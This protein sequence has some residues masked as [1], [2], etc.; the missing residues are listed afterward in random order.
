MIT[1]N[2]KIFTSP[3]EVTLDLISG[4][5]KILILFHLYNGNRKRYSEIKN[6]L[7]GVSEKMLSQ[8]LRE[9]ERD[10]LI[11]KKILS[12]KPY[13]VEYFLTAKG[14]TLTPLCEFISKWGSDYL[15]GFGIDTPIPVIPFGNGNY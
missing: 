9:L 5:W 3:V 10:Q 1:L 13:R 8:Q 7:T 12:K 15:T 4:K 14:Q 2:G 11:G 6:T